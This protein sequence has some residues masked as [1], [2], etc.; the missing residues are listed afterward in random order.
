MNQIGRELVVEAVGAAGVSTSEFAGLLR[1][2]EHA[3]AA[4]PPERVVL[5]DDSD[6]ALA[7]ALVAAKL[8]IPLSARMDATQAASAN[9]A[10]ITQLASA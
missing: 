2:Y 3:L 7:A 1:T 6:E 9:G 5:A 10:V 8:L 4:E